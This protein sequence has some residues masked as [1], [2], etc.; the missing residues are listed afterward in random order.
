MV[1]ICA[2]QPSASLFFSRWD[3]SHPKEA[4]N[5]ARASESAARPSPAPGRKARSGPRGHEGPAGAGTRPLRLRRASPRARPL[6]TSA[7]PPFFRSREWPR[8]GRATARGPRGAVAPKH[9]RGF[10]RHKRARKSGEQTRRIFSLAPA[11]SWTSTSQGSQ[12]R[13][14]LQASAGIAGCPG[15]A[16][17]AMVRWSAAKRKLLPGTWDARE[18]GGCRGIPPTPQILPIACTAN[19][20]TS[21]KILDFRGFNSSI[22]LNLRGGIPRPMGNFPEGLSQAILV[23]M[24]NLSREIG[25]TRTRCFADVG[26]DVTPEE[27]LVPAAVHLHPPPRIILDTL[28]GTSVLSFLLDGRAQA[29]IAHTASPHTKDPQSKNLRV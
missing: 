22:I 4:R 15:A 19:L 16:T 11:R 14:V 20:R 1:R 3:R 12:S 10:H 27:R 21:T 23:G 29:W 26:S 8:R 17:Q 25:R 9:S 13:L 24:I 28:K 7:R 6:S 18:F 2:G 5:R